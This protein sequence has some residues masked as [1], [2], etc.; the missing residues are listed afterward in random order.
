MDFLTGIEIGA[1]VGVGLWAIDAVRR[2]LAEVRRYIRAICEAKR[3]TKALV[4]AWAKPTNKQ[5]RA[6]QKGL[7][8]NL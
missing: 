5:E 6:T 8:H 7:S 1:G 3:R 4:A 2:N